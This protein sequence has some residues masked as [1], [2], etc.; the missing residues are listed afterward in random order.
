MRI[1]TLN[2][3]AAALSVAV[4]LACSPP[5]ALP[6]TPEGSSLRTLRADGIALTAACVTTGVEKCF[7]ATDDNCNGL[8]DEGCGTPTGSMQ[9]SVAWFDAPVDLDLAVI[10]PSGFRISETARTH[11]GFRLDRDCPKESCGGQNIETMVFDGAEL[12]KGV[13]VVEV[14]LGS[15]GGGTFPVR[16][17]LGIRIGSRTLGAAVE[18]GAENDRKTLMFE[19]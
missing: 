8:I 6:E 16:G 13:Y 12:P 11:E 2:G 10:T 17:R 19:I 5:S 1:G 18:L 14:R 9:V 4:A 15:L 3:G 7:D